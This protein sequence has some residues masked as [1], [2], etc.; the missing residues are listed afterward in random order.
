MFQKLGF[1]GDL[2]F[3]WGQSRSLLHPVMM[4]NSVL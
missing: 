4:P 3:W 1:W 2:H